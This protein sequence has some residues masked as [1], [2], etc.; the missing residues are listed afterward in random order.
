MVKKVFISWDDVYDLLDIIHAQIK[1]KVKY[2]TGIPRGGTLLAIL[3]SHRFGISYMSNISPHYPSL[4]VLD[5]I[6]DTGITL[7]E[8]KE[9]FPQPMYAT[10]HYKDKSVSLPDY[11]GI[12][13]PEDYGWIVYPWE[14][15]DSKPVQDYLDN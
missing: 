11:Y 5:D 12:K 7:K 10:L 1:D 2:V 4:L 13:I 15:D 8:I 9:K 6:A 3:Y 14:R